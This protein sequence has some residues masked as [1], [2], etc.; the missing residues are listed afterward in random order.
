MSSIVLDFPVRQ[1]SELDCNFSKLLRAS[2]KHDGKSW[3]VR[4]SYLKGC[5][6]ELNQLRKESA[7]FTENLKKETERAVIEALKVSEQKFANEMVLLKRDMD[8]ENRLSDLKIKTLEETSTRR[9]TQ[10]ETLQNRLDEAK[11]QVENIALKAI[12]GASNLRALDRVNAIALEQ[13]K[14]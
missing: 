3:Q 12:D 5:E 4:E 6:E 11:Q 1:S 7:T 2:A 9:L 14:T 10:I 13:A 8:A